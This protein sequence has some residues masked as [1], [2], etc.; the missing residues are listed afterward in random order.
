MKSKTERR[1][2]PNIAPFQSDAARELAERINEVFI[3]KGV[4]QDREK[5]IHLQSLDSQLLTSRLKN[6][7]KLIANLQQEI[8][9]LISL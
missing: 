6:T 8:S 7:E 3:L 4:V 2:L 5:L 9:R 1:T